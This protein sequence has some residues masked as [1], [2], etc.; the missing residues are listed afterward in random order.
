VIGLLAIL[1]LLTAALLVGAGVYHSC[2]PLP[3]GLSFR[4]RVHPA[5]G[6]EFLKDLSWVDGSGCRHLKQQIFDEILRMIRGAQAFILLDFF[7]FNDFTG[8]CTESGR[9]LAEEITLA[10]LAAQERHPDIRIILITDP[11]NTV[12]GGME[13]T[14]LEQLRRAGIALYLTRHDALRDSNLLYSPCWRMLLSPFGS[15]PGWILPNP[16]GPGRVSLRS[17]LVM[18]NFKANHRKVV[19]ADDADEYVALVTSANPHGGSAAHGNVALRFRGPAVMDLVESERGVPGVDS[20]GIPA[21]SLPTHVR[22]EGPLWVQVLTEGKIKERLLAELNSTGVK[23]RVALVMFYLSDRDIVR[24]LLKAC[25]RGV[26]IRLVLDP[27]KDAFGRTKNGMPNRQTAVRLHKA[28]INI[29]WGN[30]HGEQLHTKLVLIERHTGECFLM[31]GSANLTRRNLDDFNLETDVAVHGNEQEEVFREA[32]R[33]VDLLWGNK[34]GENE[35]TVA[36][37][38][39]ADDTLLRRTVAWWLERT[40]TG[41]F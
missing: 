5:T 17:Y 8:K 25:K 38:V 10:L 14:Y 3:K 36:Y 35:F 41:T 32:G 11:I 2:K 34:T 12:Y 1:A 19:V 40:G 4:G 18:L 30:T 22:S 37:P 21:I 15:G 24:A 23:E 31:L 26:H 16:F 27:N 28:G 39:Y 20:D 7:L 9:R 29:R 6:V 33:Y 13:N